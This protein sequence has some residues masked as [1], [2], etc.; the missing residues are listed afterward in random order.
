MDKK[1]DQ[2]RPV[3]EYYAAKYQIQDLGDES[4]S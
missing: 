3:V 2:I 4:A 1:F